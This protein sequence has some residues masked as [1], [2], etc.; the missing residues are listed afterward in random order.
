VR[1]RRVL[2]LLKITPRYF[3]W[4][5]KGIFCPCNVRWASGKLILREY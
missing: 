4:V 2:L 1:S 3:T 5:T